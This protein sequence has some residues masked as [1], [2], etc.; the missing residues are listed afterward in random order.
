ML[1]VSAVLCLL[2]L[3]I[4]FVTERC[5]GT[6]THLFAGTHLEAYCVCCLL[7]SLCWLPVITELG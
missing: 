5:R 1:G 4:C 7:L 2:L 6:G 3:A